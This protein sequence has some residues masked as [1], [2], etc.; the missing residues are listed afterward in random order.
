[1][2]SRGRRADFGALS[3]GVGG[4][5]RVAMRT[6]GMDWIVS[7]DVSSVQEKVT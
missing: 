4:G 1:M 2:R 7:K 5:T 6:P 3:L